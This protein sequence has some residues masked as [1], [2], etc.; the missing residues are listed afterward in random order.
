MRRSLSKPCCWRCHS[1]SQYTSARKTKSGVR[2]HQ[3]VLARLVSGRGREVGLAP[4]DKPFGVRPR[5]GMVEGDVVGDEVEHQLQAALPQ[6][7]TQALEGLAEEGVTQLFRPLIG[8]DFIVGLKLPGEDGIPDSI[9][10]PE[11]TIITSMLTASKEASYVCFCQAWVCVVLILG[12][13]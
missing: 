13:Q 4:L 11:A 7:R 12:R 5:P 3:A 1:R 8:A 2:Q 10:L 9:G 6:P